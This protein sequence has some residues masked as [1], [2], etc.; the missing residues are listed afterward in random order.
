MSV[1]VSYDVNKPFNEQYRLP[2]R[3]LR[4]KPVVRKVKAP[5]KG[6]SKF[7]KGVGFC[8]GI[9]VVKLFSDVALLEMGAVAIGV[10]VIESLAAKVNNVWLKRAI[11][12][13][14]VPALILASNV[15]A[16]DTIIA[17][18]AVYLIAKTVC[19]MVKMAGSFF[20]AI[21]DCNLDSLWDKREDQ[22]L[23]EHRKQH[24]DH[25]YELKKKRA[26]EVLRRLTDLIGLRAVTKSS[27]YDAEIKALKDEDERLEKEKYQRCYDELN[28]L[29]RG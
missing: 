18:V 4:L 6:E 24:L 2:R 11:F 3:E 1:S 26:A 21:W 28:R 29:R 8:L 14:V 22:R 7:V 23:A 12:F 25:Y 17:G 13:S 19:K 27:D 10:M 15:I 16:S 9:G 5:P 20:S